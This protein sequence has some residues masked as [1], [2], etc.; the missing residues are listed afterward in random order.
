MVSSPSNG[1]KNS[2]NFPSFVIESL[3]AGKR[4]RIF[5]T[6]EEEKEKW[7]EL[8]G[9]SDF[10]IL[11][12][13]RSSPKLAKSWHGKI[14]LHCSDDW[15]TDFM[16]LVLLSWL[17]MIKSLFFVLITCAWRKKGHKN[18]CRNAPK[19]WIYTYEQLVRWYLLFD[20]WQLFEQRFKVGW[21][22]GCNKKKK[23]Q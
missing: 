1:W 14:A 7:R 19:R 11:V 5:T 13:I 4:T 18:N 6:T 20:V 9:T 8:R 16:F 3:L 17:W 23:K 2:S 12:G 22:S 10:P 15:E 21:V